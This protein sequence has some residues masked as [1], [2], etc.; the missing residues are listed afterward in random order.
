MKPNYLMGLLVIIV[1]IL[2]IT[3]AVEIAG[4]RGAYTGT[5]VSASIS[6]AS[7][8][9]SVDT[10]GWTENEKMNYEMHGTLPA[11]LQTGGK[12]ANGASAGMVGGC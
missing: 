2:S 8:G 11:R 4:I 5:T 10:T 9:G 3:Q 6:A 1:L 12:S 7:A